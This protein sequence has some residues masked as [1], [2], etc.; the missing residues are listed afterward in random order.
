M[1][2]TEPYDPIPH[3]AAMVAGLQVPRSMLGGRSLGASLE[4]Y[5]HLRGGLRLFGWQNALEIEKVLYRALADLAEAPGGWHQ[6]FIMR[7]EVIACASCE[8]T[9]TDGEIAH[10]P[11][12][13]AL[14]RG[15]ALR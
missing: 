4:P 5:D 15:V 1:M 10:T 3:I 6:K 13:P 8:V 11:E 2:A 14:L 12:C 7:G 9:M